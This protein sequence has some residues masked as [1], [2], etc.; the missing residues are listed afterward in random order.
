MKKT[1]TVVMT[2]VLLNIVLVSCQI[3]DSYKKS[4][5][6]NYNYS[7]YNSYDIIDTGPVKGGVLNIYSTSYDTL[8]PIMTKN[9]YVQ[10]FSNLIYEGLFKVNE[11]QQAVPV[12]ADSWEV[13][14]DKLIYSFHI[15]EG[16][17]W[18][19][20]TPLTAEDV[21]FTFAKI[22]DESAESIYKSN[23][24]NIVTFAAINR[25]TFR[26]VLKK[27][28]SFT[29]ELM[30]FPIMPRHLA[31]N[32]GLV[33]QPE[34]LVP[35]GTGPYKVETIETEEY[36]KLSQNKEWWKSGENPDNSLVTPYI[37]NIKINLYSGSVTEIEAFQ[38]GDTH[39]ACVKSEDFSKYKSRPDIVLKKY[40]GRDFDFIAFNTSIPALSDKSVRA[41]NC[42]YN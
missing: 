13:S 38:T 27:P 36:I 41:G 9:L 12:L 17:R 20:G 18:H 24:K 7:I 37:D 1:L 21:E 8:D 14:E 11:S 40:P 6:D 32:E 19:D 23:L 5:E 16:V 31:D 33:R 2:A 35:V 22:Q 30:T 25:D 26:V 29:P 10:R 39:I 15:R 4:E 34:G 42:L 3:S 28:N